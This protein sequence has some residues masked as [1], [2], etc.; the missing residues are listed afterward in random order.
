MTD[1]VNAF[2]VTLEKD[3]RVDDVEE[4]QKA[5]GM[6]KGVIDVQP[7]VSTPMQHVATVRARYGLIQKMLDLLNSSEN[8]KKP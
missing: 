6:M 5:L 1:R 8:E 7:M 2:I 4:L 3:A